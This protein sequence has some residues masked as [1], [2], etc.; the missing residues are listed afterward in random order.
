M[1]TEGKPTVKTTEMRREE[2]IDGYESPEEVAEY[3][4]YWIHQ[5]DLDFALRGCAIEEI[6]QNFFLQSYCE[7]LESFPYTDMLAPSDYESPAYMKINQARMTAVYS[8]MVEQCIGI[9]GS[10]VDLEIVS[11][12]SDIPENADGYYY[13]DIRDVCSIVG[14]R[15]VRNVV[16]QMFVDGCAETDDHDSCTL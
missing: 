16:I 12:V 14:A 9:L 10:E 1:I 11:I 4:L 13:Q 7:V 15:D 5:D 3:V 8:D 6:A 2:T